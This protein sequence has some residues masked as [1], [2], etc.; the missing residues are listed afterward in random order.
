MAAA[1]K[2]QSAVLHNVRLCSI[3]N[4]RILQAPFCR[5]KSHQHPAV[6][7][8]SGMYNKRHSEC[9]IFRARQRVYAI[10]VKGYFGDSDGMHGIFVPLSVPPEPGQLKLDVTNCRADVPRKSRSKAVYGRPLKNAL[11][12]THR[13]T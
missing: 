1:V 7:F 9:L 6:M 8:Y 13:F 3:F 4:S 5:L 2:L 11:M 10:P 12:T